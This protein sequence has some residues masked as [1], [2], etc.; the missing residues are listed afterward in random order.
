LE[1]NDTFLLNGVQLV[2]KRII[3]VKW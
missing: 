2:L 3:D 1:S